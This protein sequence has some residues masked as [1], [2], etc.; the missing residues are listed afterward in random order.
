M[1][2][3]VIGYGSIGKRHVRVL[4]D[5]GFVVAVVSAQEDVLELSYSDVGAALVDFSPDYVVICNATHL[6]FDIMDE[7]AIGNFQGNV[8]VEK[9]LFSTFSSVPKNKFASIYV[10]YNLRFHP[11]LSRLKSLL[12]VNQVLSTNV[13]VGQYLPDWRPGIDYRESY[14]AKKEQGG[15]V[16]R[17]LSHEMDYLIW[18]LGAWKSVTAH[19]GTVSSL[20]ITTEDV[21]T[22][23]MSTQ[24]CPIVSVQM[25][26]LDRVKRRRIVINTEKHCL[27]IDLINNSILIDD[28]KEVFDVGV[29]TTYSEMH[30]AVLQNDRSRLCSVDEAKNTIELIEVAERCNGRYWEYN[31]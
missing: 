19:G 29:D 17:D 8:L 4:K 24:R 21:Y 15:G 28:V 11:I 12:S 14:S 23:L 10:G 22:I 30:L 25:S 31:E 7:L 26:Y 18:L 6:H 1:R 27:E 5:I 20:E 3:L 2:A 9:P 16:L 13:Y